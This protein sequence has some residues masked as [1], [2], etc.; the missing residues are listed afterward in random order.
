MKTLYKFIPLFLIP[1]A[2]IF[3]AYSTGSPGGKTGSPGDNGNN[4]TQCHSGT[5]QNASN[6]ITTNI[7]GN[8]YVGGETY[9]IT[10]IGTHSGVVKFGSEVTAEDESGNKVGTFII[11][12]ASQNKFTNGNA[13]VTHTSG[14]T[15][16]SGNTK[17]WMFDWT[18]P[19][20][21]T[22]EVTF[23]G[24]FNAANGNGGT[25]GDVIYLTSLTVGPDVTGIN[26]IANSF[27]FYPNPS[28][29]VV[30]FELPGNEKVSEIVI[31]NNN[32]QMVKHVDMAYDFRQ[33]DLGNLTKGIYFVKIA[34]DES[35][36]MQK[37]VIN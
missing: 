24:A 5:P 19:E 26:D 20:G 13:A 10:A 30:N 11:T 18:A 28:T 15:T 12:N 1:V 31:Y 8:G 2:I 16:P 27:R 37:L 25:T 33:V 35:T 23:Y 4:C 29:G 36:G 21:S 9:T 7:P 34:G 3:M 14:G 32:G 17:E 22:G 6:W